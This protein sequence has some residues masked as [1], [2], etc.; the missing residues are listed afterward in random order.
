MF[1]PKKTLLKVVAKGI[2]TSNQGI[3]TSNKKLLVPLKVGMV[4]FSSL[5]RN[6]F[7]SPESGEAI[8][9][10]RKQRNQWVALSIVSGRFLLITS[11]NALVTR[12]Y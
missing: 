6:L 11:G 10:E 12:C 1:Q 2:T 9:P 7:D 8:L 3:A 5:K 4:L